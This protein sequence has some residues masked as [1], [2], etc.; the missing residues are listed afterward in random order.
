MPSLISVRLEAG[1]VDLFYLEKNYADEMVAHARIEAPNECCGILA[2]VDKRVI[3]FYRTSNREIS[4]YRYCINPQELIAI[5]KEI[6][7]NGWELLGVYHSHTHT[8]AYPSSTDVASAV[9]PQSLY[10]IISLSN[11]DEAVIKAF[12]IIEGKVTETE[13]RII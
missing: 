8:E 6:Q 11:P 2:G 1:M 4:P 13:L 12:R 5:Y 7:K 9:L 10:F 3:K